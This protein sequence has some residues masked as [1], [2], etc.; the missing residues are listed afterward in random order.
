MDVALV[1]AGRGETFHY[2][3]LKL[4]EYLAAGRA[5]VAPNVPQLAARL[6]PGVEAILVPPGDTKALRTA[7]QHLHDEPALRNR[8]GAAAR[9]AAIAQWSWDHAIRQ[10]LERLE[11]P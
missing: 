10:V 4:A 8:L 11:R 9:A 3:P 7:L 5:V 6:A 2:S 1:L